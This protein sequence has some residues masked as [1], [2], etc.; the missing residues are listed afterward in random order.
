[1]KSLVKVNETPPMYKRT[2]MFVLFVLFSS[3]PTKDDTYNYSNNEEKSAT[4]YK[5]K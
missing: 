2:S 5:A 4:T 3:L 1:M